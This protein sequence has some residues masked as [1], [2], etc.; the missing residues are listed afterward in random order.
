[1]VYE[2]VDP[3]SVIWAMASKKGDFLPP[4]SAVKAYLDLKVDLMPR[5]TI[6]ASGAPQHDARTMLPARPDLI[7][8]A[9]FLAGRAC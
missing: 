6:P 4:K 7:D 3:V 9:G 2:I 5:I 1:V 8:R